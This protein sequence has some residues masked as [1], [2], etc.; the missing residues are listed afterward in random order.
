[1]IIENEKEYVE[2]LRGVNHHIVKT[3]KK[4]GVNFEK[5]TLFNEYLVKDGV[6]TFSYGVTVMPI[7][8]IADPPLFIV[9]VPSA[10][11]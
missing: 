2:S 8:F 3:L 5:I 10:P 1:M 11:N 6:G 7:P 4:S 9:K